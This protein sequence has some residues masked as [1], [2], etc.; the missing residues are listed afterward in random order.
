M[1]GINRV[2]N[3]DLGK[4]DKDVRIIGDYVF[5]TNLRDVLIRNR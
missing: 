2:L 5:N 4:I 3:L 1:I